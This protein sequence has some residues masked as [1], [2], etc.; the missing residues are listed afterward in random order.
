MADSK[1]PH[2]IISAGGRSFEIFEEH[3][4]DFDATYLLYPDFEEEPVYTAEGRP[5]ATAGQESCKYSVSRFNREAASEDCGGCLWFFRETTP[6]DL[7]GI[8][9]SDALQQQQ[10]D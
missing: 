5:F 4:E 9:M 10:S 1:Y 7:I 3:A 6:L 8:C 2:Q